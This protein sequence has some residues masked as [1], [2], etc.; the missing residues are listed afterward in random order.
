VSGERLAD[1]SYAAMRG[2]L[3]SPLTGH[4]ALLMLESGNWVIW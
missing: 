1:D 4:R 2:G 3:P